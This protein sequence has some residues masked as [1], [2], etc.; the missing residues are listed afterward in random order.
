MEE[1]AGFFY[2]FLKEMNFGSLRCSWHVP[3]LLVFETLCSYMICTYKK[4]IVY[5]F[6]PKVKCNLHDF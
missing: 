5:F 1:L 4:K 3:N 6:F 2:K